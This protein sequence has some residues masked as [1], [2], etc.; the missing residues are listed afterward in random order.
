[1]FDGA[2]Y[3]FSQLT[4]KLLLLTLDWRWYFSRDKV[5]NGGRRWGQERLFCSLPQNTRLTPRVLYDVFGAS[6]GQIT[7]HYVRRKIV[8]IIESRNEKLS[9]KHKGS[10]NITID[11]IL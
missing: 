11:D 7:F 4:R 1:M 5:E 8:D 6:S 2:F 9:I 10:F 3:S